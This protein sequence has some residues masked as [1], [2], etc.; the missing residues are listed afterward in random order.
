MYYTPFITI[1]SKERLKMGK[2]FKYVPKSTKELR[3]IKRA[4][5][6]VRRGWREQARQDDVELRWII[7]KEQLVQRAGL[8]ETNG[9]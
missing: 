1:N 3:R 7:E 6:K 5:Q 9:E 2:K 8:G 4:K